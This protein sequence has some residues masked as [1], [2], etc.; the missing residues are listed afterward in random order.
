MTAELAHACMP[1]NLMPLPTVSVAPD[2]V[3]V[4]AGREDIIDRVRIHG[5]PDIVV[6]ALSTDRNR[7]LVDKLQ[8]YAAAGVPEYWI[9]D[10]DAD[11][12]IQLQLE[13]DGACRERAVLT[14]EDTLTTPLFPEFSLPLAQLFEHPARIRR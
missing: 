8:W 13:D 9:L 5:T 1:M 6:E 3:V 14:V 7:D 12:F 11:A 2:V 4:R 10:G